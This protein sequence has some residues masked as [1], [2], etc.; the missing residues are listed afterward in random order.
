MPARTGCG[1]SRD[2]ERTRAIVAAHPSVVKR[3]DLKTV[4]W[5]WTTSPR[6][7]SRGRMRTERIVKKTSKALLRVDVVTRSRLGSRGGQY[8]PS[9]DGPWR[10]GLLDLRVHDLRDCPATSITKATTSLTGAAPAW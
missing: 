4:A 6:S 8:E 2:G 10:R 1:P 9:R 3:G 5:W 7:G